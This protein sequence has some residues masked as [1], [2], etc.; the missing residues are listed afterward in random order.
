MKMATQ[1]GL[2]AP[3]LAIGSELPFSVI[4]FS[5]D[6]EVSTFVC[7]LNLNRLL[8]IALFHPMFP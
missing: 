2:T 4:L 1:I 6:D 8:L 7:P 3:T 5:P